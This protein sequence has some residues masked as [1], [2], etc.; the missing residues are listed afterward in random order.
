MT[1]A[2]ASPSGPRPAPPTLDPAVGGGDSSR[3]FE[4]IDANHD[5][6]ITPDEIDAASAH[7]FDRMDANHDGVLTPDERA[8]GRHGYGGGP[9]SGEPA[10]PLS[11]GG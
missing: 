10:Q 7:R 11:P 5:G 6:Y 9:E 3:M 1:A 8:N 4:R 2:S